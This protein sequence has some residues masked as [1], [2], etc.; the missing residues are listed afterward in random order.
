[1]SHGNMDARTLRASL[2][3]PV[4][5]SDGHWIEYGPHLARGLK[6]HGGAA[7]VE[8]FMHFGNEIAGTVAMAQYIGRPHLRKTTAQHQTPEPGRD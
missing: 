7:A 4:I 2:D 1:M 3:H 8:G 6:R 5:D